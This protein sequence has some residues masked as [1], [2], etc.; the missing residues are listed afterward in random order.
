M[1]PIKKSALA[2]VEGNRLLLV[3]KSGSSDLLTPGGKIEEGESAVEALK[4]EIVEEL[5][6]GVDESSL[7]S[8]G[9]FEDFTTDG[10]STVSIALYSGKLAGKPKASSEIEELV[11]VTAK[12]SAL[13][14]LTPVIRNKILPFLV[15]KGML[16]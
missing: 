6:C 14:R 9:S 11:W 4:R 13:P 8:L 12:D 3:R 15:G 10:S 7:V 5:G 16:K 2:V 1:K